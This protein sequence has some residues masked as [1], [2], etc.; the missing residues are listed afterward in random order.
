MIKKGH[1]EGGINGEAAARA[2]GKTPLMLAVEAHQLDVIDYLLNHG[3]DLSLK[4]ASGETAMDIA[5]KQRAGDAAAKLNAYL[6]KHPIP[7]VYYAARTPVL[8]IVSGTNQSG[9]PDCGAPEPLVVYVMNKEDG[10]LMADA[11]VKFAVDDGG[12]H[13]L[14]GASSPDSPSLLVRTDDEGLCSAN[15][16]LPET[17]NTPVAITASAGI[18]DKVS[19]VKFT[20]VTNDG[21]HGASTS[22]FNPTD[23]TASLNPDGSIDV[24]WANHTDDETCIKIW[25]R[26]PG[27]WKLALTLPPHATSAHIPP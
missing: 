9:S 14:L 16:H 12:K 21:S 18:A 20:A 7:S 23:Q 11:P 5:R 3:A 25:I 27:A 4:D 6:A 1:L 15:L 8:Y 22:C 24:T 10:Q 17:P 2:D 13:L 26:T 19:T